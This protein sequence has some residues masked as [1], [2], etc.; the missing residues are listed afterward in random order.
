MR[1]PV[2][3]SSWPQVF[4]PQQLATAIL[5]D[6][7]IGLSQARC[8]TNR[9]LGAARQ[10]RLLS[11]Q[12]SNM[13]R[14]R[15]GLSRGIPQEVPRHRAHS[16]Q[17][18][19]SF[20]N[21]RVR[22]HAGC[23]MWAYLIF[24]AATEA[25]S[26]LGGVLLLIA[27]RHEF[28]LR[29]QNHPLSHLVLF[30]HR[31][32]FRISADS[33]QRVRCSTMPARIHHGRMTEPPTALEIY[34]GPENL[35]CASRSPRVHRLYQDQPPSELHRIFRRAEREVD[36]QLPATINLHLI[37]TANRRVRHSVR[38]LW[39]TTRSVNIRVGRT[40]RSTREHAFLALHS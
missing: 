28:L 40:W 30:C 38:Q 7:Q 31:H 1:P 36:L 20:C 17:S 14:R 6:L 22:P 5:D 16:C 9:H 10:D 2:Y 25:E 34:N 3:R 23:Y 39:S 24:S 21:L 18:L 19:E 12:S 8:S 27:T 33:R 13:E 15:S 35:F 26:P 11:V 29:H 32:R 4:G 37:L